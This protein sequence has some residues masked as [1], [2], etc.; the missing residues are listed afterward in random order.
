MAP[1]LTDT[2]RPPGSD[3]GLCDRSLQAI[4]D[5]GERRIGIRPVGRRLVRQHEHGVA[6]HQHPRSTLY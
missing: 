4:G 5:E 2:S 6:Q 1:A 3:L